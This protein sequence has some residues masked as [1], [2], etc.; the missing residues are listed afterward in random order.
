MTLTGPDLRQPMEVYVNPDIATKRRFTRSIAWQAVRFVA[1]VWAAPYSAVGLA[2]G[3]IATVFGASMRVHGG[4]LE[5]GGGRVWGL[6]SDLPAPCRISAITLGHVVLGIDHATLAAVRTHEQVH[7][8]QYEC[9]G[10]FFVP[11]YFLSGLVQWL[12]GRHP[13]LDNRFEREAFAKALSGRVECH[14][15]T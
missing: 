7:I 12:R 2:C 10:P 5:F 3:L 6:V 9:W 4:A 15:S 1:Y 11:A 13:Y 14:T 8:R